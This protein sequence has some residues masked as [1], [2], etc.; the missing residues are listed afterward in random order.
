[1]SVD[2]IFPVSKGGSNDPSNIRLV[3]KW[4]NI[5]LGTHTDD[6]FIEMCRLIVKFN[7]KKLDK[8]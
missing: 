1:M 8:S 4:T 6:E 2:H 3:E 5:M 7:D